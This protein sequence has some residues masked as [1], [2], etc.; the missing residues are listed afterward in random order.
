[1]PEIAFYKKSNGESPV[2]EFLDSLTAK[3]A[4][5]A[6]W[7]LQVIEELLKYQQPTSRNLLIQMT[8]GRSG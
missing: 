7:T 2:E 4:Q 1:M 5:K 8:F 3:Q 6:V